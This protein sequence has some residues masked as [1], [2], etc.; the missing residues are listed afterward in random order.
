MPLLQ[1]RRLEGHGSMDGG[2][3]FTQFSHFIDIMYW[4]FGDITDIQGRFADFNHQGLTA[5]EDSG[6][7]TFR[8]G[9][10]A[11]AAST[12]APP[13]GTATWRAASR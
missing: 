6:L 13:F 3:L 11:W 4:L 9:R 10:A 5:F 1:A 7:V 2:T 12:T 8:S